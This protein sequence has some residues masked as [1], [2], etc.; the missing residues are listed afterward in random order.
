M[1]GC[2]TTI[3]FLLNIGTFGMGI[4]VFDAAWV[5]MICGEDTSNYNLVDFHWYTLLIMIALPIICLK[6]L[7]K[8][9]RYLSEFICSFFSNEQ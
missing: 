6:L 1:K 8:G 2:L 4:V 9:S 5:P 7:L 3:I